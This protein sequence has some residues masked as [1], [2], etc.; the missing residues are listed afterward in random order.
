MEGKLGAYLPYALGE[1]VLVMIG[2]LLALQVN[3]WNQGIMD[4]KI[5]SNYLENMVLDI[6]QELQQLNANQAQLTS[7]LQTISRL[8]PFLGNK[9]PRRDT[10]IGPFFEL[11]QLVN[12]RPVNTTYQTLINSGDMKLIDDFQVRRRIEEHYDLHE[13]I[14]KDYRRIEKIHEKYLGDFFISEIDYDKIRAGNTDFFDNPT[15]KNIVIS[16][17]GAQYFVINANKLC[18]ES[19]KSLLSALQDTQNTNR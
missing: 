13:L 10:L 16:L 7:N 1:I 18:I 11:A 14:L 12:F 4:D 2:I 15:L 17:E 6:E 9:G 8:K 3:N 19:N 5:E